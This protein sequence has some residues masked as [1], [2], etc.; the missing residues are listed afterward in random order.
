MLSFSAMFP[1]SDT[2]LHSLMHQTQSLGWWPLVILVVMVIT[3]L[4]LHKHINKRFP[5]GPP[6]K[7]L[8]G[9]IF[10]VSA[11]AGWLKFTEYKKTYGAYP[12]SKPEH[13]QLTTAGVAGDIIYFHGLGNKVLVLNSMRVILD[14]LEKKAN[15]YSDRPVF[16][17]IG[18]LMGAG[19]V[20][21][22]STMLF[23]C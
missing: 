11:Q 23:C 1:P 18:E 17:M 5:P 7:P 13:Y 3:Y 12:V 6:A 22:I 20:I 15:I 14:L 4:I 19:Q 10:E 9:N 8:V 16:T 21:I 2:R